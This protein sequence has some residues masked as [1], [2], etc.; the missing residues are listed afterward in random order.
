MGRQPWSSW[1]WEWVRPK[2]PDWYPWRTQSRSWGFVAPMVLAIFWQVAGHAFDIDGTT[3]HVASLDIVITEEYGDLLNKRTQ[4][5][6][7]LLARQGAIFAKLVSSSMAWW[8]RLQWTQAFE[9]WRRPRP[10]ALGTTATSSMRHCAGWCGESTPLIFAPAYSWC[11]SSLEV[12][13]F[14]N[15][16]NDYIYN[17]YIRVYMII[18]NICM[19]IYTNS[20]GCVTSQNV[21]LFEDHLEKWFILAG[22]PVVFFR[23]LMSRHTVIPVICVTDRDLTWRIRARKPAQ[24]ATTYWLGLRILVNS[25]HFAWSLRISLIFNPNE[26]T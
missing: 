16:L 9:G 3:L 10:R 4:E 5:K 19:Y 2:S 7:L 8:R 22:R 23:F 26:S 17:F 11:K 20:S 12:V 18:N 15:I 6:W 24:K 21:E 14:L 25:Y 1:V 13:R